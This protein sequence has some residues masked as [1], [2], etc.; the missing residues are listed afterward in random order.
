MELKK[1]LFM[2]KSIFIIFCSICFFGC[3]K[4]EVQVVNKQN[5]CEKI[6]DSFS[7]PADLEV[8]DE[9]KYICDSVLPFIDNENRKFFNQMKITFSDKNFTLIFFNRKT[10]I[11]FDK[12]ENLLL[13]F[14]ATEIDNF[15]FNKPSY[16]EHYPLTFYVL[17]EK[18]LPK[19]YFSGNVISVF[20]DNVR[21]KKFEEYK[22]VMNNK[23]L[24]DNY[25]V[26]NYSE[27]INVVKEL[28][29]GNYTI[30]EDISSDILN[31]F[32]KE[33]PIWVEM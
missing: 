13:V 8:L 31:Y 29:K 12:K 27:L 24:N 32:Y 2:K 15:Y 23:F 30:K 5:D 28:E 21:L 22:V 6:I 17:D 3:T 9:K 7:F 33:E 18:Y 14:K 10:K 16:K 26:F 19:Y 11:L 1:V 25:E 4:K 20:K